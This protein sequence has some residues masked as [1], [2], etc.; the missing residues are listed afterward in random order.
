MCQ[1]PSL[2]LTLCRVSFFP[3]SKLTWWFVMPLF[4]FFQRSCP[5]LPLWTKRQREEIWSGGTLAWLNILSSQKTE[6]EWDCKKDYGHGQVKVEV[7]EKADK[8]QSL[9]ERE[10][11]RRGRGCGASSYLPPSPPFLEDKWLMVYK[12][13]FFSSLS[14]NLPSWLPLGWQLS[15]RAPLVWR[16]ALYCRQLMLSF[17][18][19]FRLERYHECSNSQ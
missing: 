19:Q 11:E 13:C 2:S 3:G 18:S 12:Q 8:R 4:C 6:W 1:N 9:R 16:T 7:N 10:R 14:Q 17:R 15:I 5:T